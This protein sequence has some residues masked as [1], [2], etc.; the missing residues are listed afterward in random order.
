MVLS[1]PSAGSPGITIHNSSGRPIRCFVECS[2]TADDIVST[3]VGEFIAQRKPRK[4]DSAEFRM[5]CLNTVRVLA[6]NLACLVMAG[7]ALWL[8]TP[9]SKTW[10]AENRFWIGGNLTAATVEACTEFLVGQGYVAVLAGNASPLRANRRA[11]GI[12]PTAKFV[13]LVKGLGLTIKDIWRSPSSDLIQL[14]A[15]KLRDGSKLRLPFEWTE[16][17]EAK[18]TN[19]EGINRLLLS[20]PINLNVSNGQWSEIMTH[21]ARKQDPDM[22]E[23]IADGS[24]LDLTNKTL[25]RVF[26]NASFDQGGR[27]YGGW[28]QALP[29]VW[30]SYVTI[31]GRKVVELDYAAMHPT[32]LSHELG[33]QPTTN[34]YEI[35]IGTKS[36]VKGTF[37]A[38]INA[39]G[40]SIKEV[41][42]FDEHAVGMD[43]AR[44]LQCVKEHYQPYR[45]YFGTGYG[46]KL[47]KLDS[48]IAEAV[49]LHF[50][51]QGKVVLPV[52][53]SFLCDE[54]LEAELAFVME[55]QFRLL[56][57]GTIR[58]KAKRLS[59]NQR[60]IL[61]CR[62]HTA[63]QTGVPISA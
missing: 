6:L 54:R 21:I 28:W 19:L 38:L 7:R 24:T 25:Y 16:D 44:F 58:L 59:Q 31:N 4:A 60:Q 46:L 12:R 23:E 13:T 43:W 8:Q 35:G 34:F 42:G 61:R 52:H 18:A 47:Q 29:K 62:L 63:R 10:Y 15:P 41:R 32:A 36:V 17:L 57:G 27:F 22:P 9:A 3:L 14:R 39:R 1:M 5:K 50:A 20:T 49:M 53:D 2:D 55:E 45:S 56:T 51:A 26:N 40:T 30:R 48:D 11:A 37:N 33:L